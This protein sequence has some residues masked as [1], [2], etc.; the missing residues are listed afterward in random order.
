MEAGL[1]VMYLN[2]I[3]KIFKY[4]HK[5]LTKQRIDSKSLKSYLESNKS[6][7]LW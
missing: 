4:H 1:E 6:Y 5:Q 2:P 7:F 3:C